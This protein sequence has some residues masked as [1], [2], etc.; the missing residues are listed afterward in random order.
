MPN[1]EHKEIFS[2]QKINFVILRQICLKIS[3]CVSSTMRIVTDYVHKTNL[4]VYGKFRDKGSISSI[5][6]QSVFNCRKFCRLERKK[7]DIRSKTNDIG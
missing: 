1:F 2:G 7:S 3:E 5:I 6:N 4:I